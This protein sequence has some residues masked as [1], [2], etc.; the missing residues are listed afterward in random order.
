MR[1][2]YFDTMPVPI[3]LAVGVVNKKNK[4]DMPVNR[5]FSIIGENPIML[6]SAQAFFISQPEM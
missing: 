2:G 5:W 1:R 3:E 4:A 6:Y